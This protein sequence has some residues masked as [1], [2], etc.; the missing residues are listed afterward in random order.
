MDVHRPKLL[1]KDVLGLWMFAVGLPEASLVRM[2][3]VACLQEGRLEWSYSLDVQNH[4]DIRMMVMMMV[5]TMI[6]ITR[7][8]CL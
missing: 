3:R 7:L 8:E 6:M 2:W 4:P 1:G 5:V